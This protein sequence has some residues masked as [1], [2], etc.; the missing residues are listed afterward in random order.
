MMLNTSHVCVGLL[1]AFGKN[2][3]SSPLPILKSDCHFVIEL[4][5]FLA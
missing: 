2:V 5:E 4:Y 1:H 3:H